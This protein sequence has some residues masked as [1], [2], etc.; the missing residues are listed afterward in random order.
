MIL[1]LNKNKEFT[2]FT[3]FLGVLCILKKESVMQ[4]MVRPVNVITF[5]CMCYQMWNGGDFL[6]SFLRLLHV[7]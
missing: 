1:L 7:N 4:Y 2:P 3:Q 6:A 5:N